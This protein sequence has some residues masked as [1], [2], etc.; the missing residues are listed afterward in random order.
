MKII[1]QYIKPPIPIRIYDW[2]AYLDGNEEDGPY[3]Y[4]KTECEAIEDLK[5]SMEDMENE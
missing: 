4:G 5:I 2:V 1:T 3:G